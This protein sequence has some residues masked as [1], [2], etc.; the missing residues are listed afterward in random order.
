MS[1]SLKKND[2]VS[3]VLKVKIEKSDYADLLDKHLHKLRR[4]INMPGFRKGMAPLGIVKKLYGKQ[5]LAEEVNKLISEELNAYIRDNDIKMLGEPIPNETEQQPINFDTD[6]DFEFCFDVALSP[7]IDFELTKE[8]RLTFYSLKVDDEQID[9]QVR[10][11][12]NHFGSYDTVDKVEEADVVKG[13]VTELENGEPKDGGIVVENAVLTPSY[14]KDEIEQQK[15]IGAEPDHKIVFNPYEAYKG[16]E[17]E[18]ASFLEIDRDQAKEMKSDFTFEVKEITRHKAAE[19]NQELF[20]RIFGPDVVQDEAA[21]RDKIKEF[22]AGRFLPEVE[23]RFIKDMRELLVKKV[24]GLAFADDILKR[25][26]LKDGSKMTK[27]QVD[28]DYP[29]VIEDLKYHLVKDKLT[30]AYDIKIEKE[31]FEAYARRVVRAQIAQYGITSISE[32]MMDKYVEDMLNKEEMVSNF[33]NRIIEE[34]LSSVIKEKITID[35]KEVT[36]EEFHK[37]REETGGA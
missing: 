8:D 5:A 31:D 10:M 33:A 3:G 1:V 29:K 23:Y 37:I 11:Y 35:V 36:P 24:S 19:L 18:I 26:M 6:E 28:D 30:K 13:C 2:A 20:D 27:E 14:M 25:W 16:A 32:E 21:F 34:K 9:E 22:L 7:D 4:Q 15:F 12:C 17:A